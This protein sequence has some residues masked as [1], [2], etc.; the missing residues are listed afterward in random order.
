M[1]FRPATAAAPRTC[2]NCGAINPSMAKQCLKCK[3]L[4]ED[5][6]GA[7][8]PSGPPGSRPASPRTLS[9]LG[10]PKTPMG[11]RPPEKD[12]ERTG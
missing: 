12:G 4:F 10:A 1:C 7:Q 5:P 8:V 9:G 11:D 3:T 2:S 6:E